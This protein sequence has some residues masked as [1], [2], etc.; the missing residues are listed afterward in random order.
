[1][2]SPRTTI[3]VTMTMSSV[4]PS[5]LERLGVVGNLLV[6]SRSRLPRGES[7]RAAQFELRDL[8]LDRAALGRDIAENPPLSRSSRSPPANTLITLSIRNTENRNNA[9]G[10]TKS[11]RERRSAA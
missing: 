9:I 11:A 1:M 2:P 10:D 8:G 5:N 4:S 6:E 3:S 7:F